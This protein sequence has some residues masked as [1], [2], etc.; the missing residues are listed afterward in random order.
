MTAPSPVI[1]PTI[2]DQVYAIL[3]AEICRG[4]FEDGQRLH[5]NELATRLNV[6]RSPV[7]EAL[8]QLASDGLVLELP[9][10]GVFVKELTPKDID[11]I[12]EIRLLLECYG[13]RRS[14][15]HMTEELAEALRRCREDL[16]RFHAAEDIT[17][18]MNADGRLHHMLLQI[19]GNDLA[20]SVYDKISS[21]ALKFRVISLLGKERFD[22]S[23]E[24]HRGIITKVLDGDPEGA[25]AVNE[26]HLR[27][28]KQKIIEHLLT[29][30][31][32]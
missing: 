22:E 19:S 18:Y 13:I 20:R 1:S 10:K 9:N 2:K 26:R 14:A 15:G 28:A 23:V 17:Q 27:R 25:V 6:S 31:K 3:K 21:L 5:E 24:E 16:I 7:R 30:K 29:R 12:F 8:R 4:V 32:G 11:D